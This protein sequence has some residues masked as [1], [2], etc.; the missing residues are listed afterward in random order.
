MGED[1]GFRQWV[2]P[3]PR[4]VFLLVHGLG[5]HT[6]RWEM[7]A[8]FLMKNG[9]SSY[10]IELSGFNSCRKDIM[11]LR[12]IIARDNPSKKI[13]LLG[14]SLGGLVSFM[15][16]AANPGKFDGL[17][18]FSPAFASKLK[19]SLPDYIKI[20]FALFYNCEKQFKLPFDSSM[21]TRDV[22]YRA[23]MDKDEHEKR[24]VSAVVLAKILFLQIYV[25]SIR[26]K[27]KTPILFLVAG[28]DKI[29]DN[30]GAVS[31]FNALA[32]DD[33]TFIEYPDM[34]HSLSIELGKE[35]VFRDVL[36]WVEKRI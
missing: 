18:C 6:G 13:F 3:K 8:D 23:V 19:L 12:D 30:R 20:F 21:C 5:A 31:I 36:S 29:A 26:R 15:L 34:Y 25:R 14:E 10:A 9:I 4:A 16:T 27:M 11:R 35:K 17:V 32:A 1:I 33:K 7:M 2:T 28:D 24:T 22:E